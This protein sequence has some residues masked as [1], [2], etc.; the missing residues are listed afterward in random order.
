MDMNYERC[1]HFSEGTYTIGEEAQVMADA[2]A[3]A[4]RYFA[5]DEAL[6]DA[7]YEKCAHCW[8]FIE[9]N[10]DYYIA[11]A[12][13]G[14]FKVAQYIHLDNGEKEHDHDATPSGDIRRLAEWRAAFPV[15]F[16]T[17]P[18]G[19]T[20]PNSIH[21]VPPNEWVVGDSTINQQGDPIAEG[22][23]QWKEGNE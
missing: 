19:M 22:Q 21:F 12:S 5:P 4:N 23:Q 1:A 6:D 10:L 13:P 2:E 9:S 15:L 18:D 20:G 14:N 16:V 17:Y 11:E 7:S 8:H 3:Y